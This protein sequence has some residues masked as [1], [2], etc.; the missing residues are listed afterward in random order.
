M[1]ASF[2]LAGLQL[3][4][5]ISSLSLSFFSTLINTIFDPI[6]NIFLDWFY[7]KSQKLSKN[8]WPD[9]GSRLT[10]IANCCFSFLMIMVNFSLIVESVR[11]LI[12]GEGSTEASNSSGE[13]N[14]IH[15][16]S[17]AA[18]GVAFLVKIVLC[19]YCGL[20]KHLSTQIEMLY[21]D[22]RNDLPVNGFGILT[23]AGGTVLRWWIDPAGSIIISI[24][25]IIV[26]L[27]TLV[28]QFKCLAGMSA[29]ERVRKRI[30]YKVVNFDE[31]IVQISSC[32]VYH[33]GQDLNVRIGVIMDR[34]TPIYE[35]QQL[36]L[37]LQNELSEIEN[38]HAVYVEVYATQPN[39]IV[40]PTV[41]DFVPSD[42]STIAET[43]AES[44][45][46]SRSGSETE[47]LSDKSQQSFR[48]TH[49]TKSA[50]HIP[51]ELV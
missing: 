26:W 1:G 11:S 37:S 10:T 17:I 49:S 5:A 15:V 9:G 39:A 44:G 48:S 3:Y 29:E 24:G 12:E 46:G 36:A 2:V 23:S 32:Y 34:S 30:L 8:K 51:A 31:A 50:L 21:I 35:S 7:K 42:L 27:L 19:V 20:C 18:V 14:G 38:V 43:R 41:S 6:S 22:H 45:S 28:R 13:I 25:V 4:A 40:L 16:P 33:C 47:Y